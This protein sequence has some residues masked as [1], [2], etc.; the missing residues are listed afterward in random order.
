MTKAGKCLKRILIIVPVMSVLTGCDLDSTKVMDYIMKPQPVV[1]GATISSDSKWINSDIEGAIDADTPTS[2]QDDFYTAINKEWLLDTKLT[3]EKPYIT[4]FSDTDEQVRQRKLALIKDE[5][6]LNGENEIGMSEAQLV[7]TQEQLIRFAE[8]AGDWEQRNQ[9]G[10]EPVRPYVEAIERIG[11]LEDMTAYLLNRNGDNLIQENLVGIEV[12]DALSGEHIYRATIT[13][14]APL[15]MGTP[16]QYRSIGKKGSLKKGYSNENVRMLLSRLGYEKN[17]IDQYIKDAY[18]FEFRLTRDRKNIDETDMDTYLRQADNSY[19][20]KEL[21]QLAGDYPLMELLKEYGLDQVESYTVYEPFYVSSVGKLYQEKYL[22]EMK[23]YYLVHTLNEAMYLL[24]RDSFET[25][26][27]QGG[28]QT[29]TEQD[30]SDEPTEETQADTEVDLLLNDYVDKYMRVPLEEVYVARY[31]SQKQKDDITGMAEDAIDYYRKM[32]TASDWLSEEGKEKAVEKLDHMSIHAIYPDQMPDYSLLSIPMTEQGNLVDAVS[33]INAFKKRQMSL[34]ADQPVDRSEWNLGMF[35]T[36]LVNAG[37]LCNDNSINICSGFLADDFLYLEDADYEQNLGRIGCIIGH[38]I[39]H[40]F[41]DNGAK[42]DQSGRKLSWWSQE[43]FQAFKL[44]TSKVEKFYNVITPYPGATVYSGVNVKGEAIA[45][46]GAVKCMLALASE[47][48][49][50][51]YEKFFIS[52]AQM[53]GT[54]DTYERERAAAMNEH[55]LGFLRA[56][57]TLQQF[58]EFYETFDI[59]P[60]DGMYLAPE[61]RILVW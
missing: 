6:N 25:V 48:P 19:S 16:Q 38:E 59:Q 15:I 56:N 9:S 61:K 2:I 1:T 3:K 43:D 35:P 44:K 53:W 33:C 4:H 24:D 26:L 49:D 14:D 29:Q 60:G 23:A 51:D 5:G 17:V 30:E 37:Y 36:T 50:F 32:L 34:K 39:T 54:K 41:D 18:Q 21:K 28:Y 7:H 42:Y 45:D 12:A 10:A 55:P 11:S 40:G 13:A 22:E 8:L 46:M 52:Y 31:C 47:Q 27:K 58:D 57:V 20:R